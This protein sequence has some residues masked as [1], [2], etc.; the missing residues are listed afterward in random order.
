MRFSI[1]GAALAA[2]AASSS[3]KV[4]KGTKASPIPFEL[5]DEDGTT[6][7]EVTLKGGEINHWI[8]DKNGYTICTADGMGVRE[9][10]LKALEE[11]GSSNTHSKVRH[12]EKEPGSSNTH[13]K[14]RHGEK[15]P[16]S[17]NTTIFFYCT[18][19]E[20]GDIVP[21]YDFPVAATDP[22][23]IPDEILPHHVHRSEMKAVEHCGA[24]CEMEL[25][26]G[27]A[28]MR[29]KLVKAPTSGNVPNL[30][31]NFKFSDHASKWVPSTSDLDILLNSEVPVNGV[32]PMAGVKKVFLDNS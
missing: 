22:D 5:F 18:P 17:S 28:R 1:K 3:I 12:G 23:S 25:S 15:E 26:R 2:L 6:L 9:R 21:N 14:V 4:A 8:E 10:H 19:T 30:V 29:R 32:A 20:D 24:Y 13:S 16:R 27:G 7:G 11:P 31:V